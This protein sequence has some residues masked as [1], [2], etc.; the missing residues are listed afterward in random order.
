MRMEAGT[1]GTPSGT[2]A[3]T[4]A[5]LAAS[6]A[7]AHGDHPAI[8][9]KVGDEWVAISYNDLNEAV[10]ETGR[11]LI[12]L[13]LEHG[14]RISILSHTRPE[15]TYANLGILASGGASV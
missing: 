13:G 12:D 9:H 1:V 8:K 7:K 5:G 6:A 4:I 3:T 2:G 14:D 15:W 11:G 10:S